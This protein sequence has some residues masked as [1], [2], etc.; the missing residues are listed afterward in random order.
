MVQ[1]PTANNKPICSVSNCDKR[2]LARG[3]CAA[4]YERWRR[5]DDPLGGGAGHGE[6]KQFYSGVVL[7]YQQDECLLWPY[8]KNNAGY[9]VLRLG[10]RV[11]VVSRC[12][13]EK[14]NGAPPSPQHEAA[15]SCG[16]GNLGCVTPRHLRWDTHAG[17]QSDMAVHGTSTRG[18]RQWMAKLTEADVREIRK[19]SESGV[20]P[21]EIAAKF[22]VARR[23][24]VHILAGTSWGWLE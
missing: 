6:P 7:P 8:S 18:E 16:N 12:V 15:H 3:W 13:C 5:H 11:Q 1:T 2:V 24:I 14:V 22:N 4:H 9:G 23:T 20:C 19:L 21:K 10:G 17:N